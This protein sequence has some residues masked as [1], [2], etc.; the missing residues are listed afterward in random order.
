MIEHK[1]FLLDAEDQIAMRAAQLSALLQ[2]ISGAGREHFNEMSGEI[3]G[4]ALW[5]AASLAEEIN[6]IA[7]TDATHAG[8]AGSNPYSCSCRA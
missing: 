4:N 8:L 2:I 1:P 5:L 3:Q 7:S 6:L